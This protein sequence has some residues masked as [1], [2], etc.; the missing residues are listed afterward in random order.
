[1][2]RPE[3][4]QFIYR[5]T[6]PAPP[7]GGHGGVFAGY[8]Y[9]PIQ[10]GNGFLDILKGVFKFLAPIGLSAAG[11]ML[12][13]LAEKRDQGATWKDAAK[14]GLR[15][16]GGDAVRSFGNQVEKNPR[17]KAMS[18]DLGHRIAD[19]VKEE[20]EQKQQS[21]SGKRRAKKRKQ[22]GGGGGGG[23][24]KRQ[25]R[26]APTVYKRRTVGSRGPTRF[27]AAAADANF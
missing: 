12:R 3:N 2:Y 11:G 8:K 10:T 17:L 1:M 13:G 18:D 16:A 27:P 5:L 24:V 23:G 9:Y 7:Q 20:R 4:Q 22:G 19:A 15:A 14:A 21:G 6:A 26:S 25:R